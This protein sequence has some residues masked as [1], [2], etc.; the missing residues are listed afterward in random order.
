MI[1]DPA[2]SHQGA[3]VFGVGGDGGAGI[4]NLDYYPRMATRCPALA[5]RQGSPEMMLWGRSIPGPSEHSSE[6]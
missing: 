1:K 2:I 3:G 5:R 4:V 6:S